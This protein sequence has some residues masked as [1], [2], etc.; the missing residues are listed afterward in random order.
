MEVISAI[1]QVAQLVADADTITTT[2]K[3]DTITIMITPMMKKQIRRNT[4][5]MMKKKNI[6]K[7]DIA[8]PTVT[9]MEIPET[10]TSMPPTSTPSE[11][12]S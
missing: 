9:L 2:E 12:C 8:I 3:K 4:S 10:S 7:K 1:I 11:T 5:M 6:K